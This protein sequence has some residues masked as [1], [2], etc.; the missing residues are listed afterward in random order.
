MAATL[1]IWIAAFLSGLAALA[2]EVLW[3]RALV[4]PL[5]NSTDAVALVT[6]GFMLGIAAGASLGGRLSRRR[7]PPLLAYAWLE[8]GLA[9]CALFAPSLLASLSAIP[10]FSSASEALPLGVALRGACALSIVTVVCLPMG[11]SIPLLVHALSAT[12]SVARH[13]G[14]L[15]AFNTAGAATGA[16]A[17]GFWAISTLG[18]ARS[19]VAAAICGGLAALLAVAASLRRTPR[20]HD[21]PSAGPALPGVRVIR[22][23]SLAA[24]FVSGMAM[25]ACEMVWA[26]L[27]TF[28]FGHDTYAFSSL[29]ALVLSG[30]ALGGLAHRAL[31]RRDP[32]RTLALLMTGFSLSTLLSFWVA[33]SLVIRAGRDPFSLESTSTFATSLRLELWRELLYTPVLVLLPAIF[34]G[35]AFPAACDACSRGRADG[36]RAVGLV[37]LVNGVG[38][39]VGALAGAFGLVS[40]AGIQGALIACALLAALCASGLLLTRIPWRTPLRVAFGLVPS[41]AVAALASSLPHALPR[42]MLHRVLGERHWDLVHYE[43]GRTGTVS[44]IRNRINGEKQLVM[45][46]VNEVTTRLVH[47]QSFKILGHL[48]PLLLPAPK[49]VVMICLGAGMS[50]G[51]V[52][53]HPIERLDVIDLSS[54]IPR[55]ARL[56]AQENNGVLDDPVM[57]LHIGDGR[58]FL[59]NSPG[60]YDVAVVDSTHP[61]SVD[62][63]ILYTREFFELLR[64]RLS[65]GG[66]V[67]QWLPLHGMSESEFKIVV[68]TFLEAFPAMTL[69]VNA[70]FETYGH[71]AYAKLVGVRGGPVRV[72]YPE[73]ARRLASTRVHRDLEP[74]GMAEPE[75]VLDLYLSGPEAIRRWTAGLPV[76]TDDHPLLPYT[77]SY[78]AG[79]RMEP[80]LLLGAISELD[81]L[82]SRPP[83]ASGR[84]RIAAHREAQG[85]V[86]AG[87]LARAQALLPGG[88]K[89]PLFRAQTATTRGYYEELARL[90]DDDPDRL[91][92]AAAQLG[93][94]GSPEAALRVYARGLELRPTDLRLQL[95]HALLLGEQGKTAEATRI[96][97]RLRSNHLDTPVVVYDLGAV[98]LTG[99][100]ASAASRHFD[101]AL[102]WDPNLAGALLA[103][104]QALLETGQLDRAR[105]RAARLLELQPWH[106]G[107]E[108]LLGLVA[109]R[110]G[111]PSEAA[112]HHARAVAI[113]PYHA[114]FRYN[115]A[116]AL[117]SLGRF[118]DAEASYR[119]SLRLRPEHAAS[120]NNLGIVL[121]AR[122]RWD[123]AAEQY[124]HVL[125]L[126]PRHAAAAHNLGVALRGQGRDDDALQAF[127][128]ALRLM[129]SSK[130]T[131]AR[132]VELGKSLD[133]C[134]PGHSP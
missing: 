11:A 61:K 126:E 119:A 44:V 15:Y 23:A 120:W 30:L 79:R 7:T 84:A 75:E 113:H 20:V 48:G 78:S 63:W 56:F 59:L 73:L 104:A 38:S 4:V 64:D 17:A 55:G 94:L 96:L 5:G 88:R 71:V 116:V 106:A 60:G 99:G 76:Q 85:L 133:D 123:D 10:S 36:A 32:I 43:E 111:D 1:V 127:C 92:E 65:P 33:A 110:A 118:E 9:S 114:P 58:Q 57:R 86:L 130:E 16:F 35:A 37:G 22:A 70:G 125:E 83:D 25:L 69:W 108:D 72:D 24:A 31:I 131:R 62:S 97:T 115:L 102:A 121:A 87:N 109:S 8:L 18:I 93:M 112:R 103:S 51:A 132:V 39:T 81:E 91:F 68:R 128:L 6:A 80:P 46:A 47:D 134:A 28:V 27:L 14:I 82:F 29:L 124:L 3:S 122:G 13:I 129:P 54:A 77:T 26:R 117:Q 98:L 42:S 40:I 34:A 19:S 107:A 45:N 50:A 95:N 52:A 2:Y 53:T 100:D 74:F 90:Y 21:R 105:A 41:I 66:I 12:G 101:E 49:R 89:L 67:V